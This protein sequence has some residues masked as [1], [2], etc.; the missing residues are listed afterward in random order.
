[1]ETNNTK[2]DAQ[3]SLFW[4]TMNM[5]PKTASHRRRLEAGFHSNF[6]QLYGVNWKAIRFIFPL[7]QSHVRPLRRTTP[8]NSHS[9]GHGLNIWRFTTAFTMSLLVCRNIPQSLPLIGLHW[10]PR[11][12]LHATVDPQSITHQ[13]IHDPLQGSRKQSLILRLRGRQRPGVTSSIYNFSRPDCFF[14][15]FSNNVT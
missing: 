5:M 8:P 12:G 6:T 13:H 2:K 11:Q 14:C 10:Q 3:R 7:S 1:M 9:K 4:L 15:S